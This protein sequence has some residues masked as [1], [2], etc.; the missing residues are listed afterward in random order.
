MER[1]CIINPATGRAV[2]IDSRLGKKLND[3]K[4]KK[5]GDAVKKLQAVVRRSV[6]VTTKKP[7]ETKTVE[8][9][10]KKTKKPRVKK[11]TKEPTKVVKQYPQKDR[12]DAVKQLQA[13]IRRKSTPNLEELRKKKENVKNNRKPISNKNKIEDIFKDFKTIVGEYN[14]DDFRVKLERFEDGVNDQM[15]NFAEQYLKDYSVY[16]KAINK[17]IEKL[18]K[19]EKDELFK[20]DP[21][22]ISVFSK[23]YYSSLEELS[24]DYIDN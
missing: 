1:H 23:K 22:I 15:I 17:H 2:K 9:P 14:M 11:S 3:A 13:V 12:A 20:K 16:E 5:E 7:I 18:N 8:I 24:L 6:S 10:D 19:E 4:L 21:E